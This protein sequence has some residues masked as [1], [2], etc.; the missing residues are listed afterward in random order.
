[1]RFPYIISI[2]VCSFVKQSLEVTDWRK[3]RLGGSVTLGCTVSYHVE[4][5]WMRH[6]PD[7]VPVIVLVAKVESDGNLFMTKQENARFTGVL[8]NRS[9]SLK[10]ENVTS[11]DLTLYYC[12][13]KEGRIL[14]FGKATRLHDFGPVTTPTPED[15]GNSGKGEVQQP[16]SPSAPA[17]TGL[18]SAPPVYSMYAGVL[19][20]GQLAMICAVVT[21]HLKSRRQHTV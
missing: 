4:I 16:F 6:Q 7:Q 19:A 5:T 14:Q 17:L 2:F 12:A 3:V 11:T 13:G 20:C 8:E 10:I 15:Y 1:M 18:S 21:V 9:V